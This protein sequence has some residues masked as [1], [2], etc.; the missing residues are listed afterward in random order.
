LPGSFKQKLRVAVKSVYSKEYQRLL[1]EL[2]QARKRAGMTQAALAETLEKP[3][4]FV[5]K[6]E[7]GE[8]RLD[9]IEFVQIAKA[10]D[11]NYKKII[12]LAFQ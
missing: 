11:V 3:Q 6:V 9:V 8:R 1:E 10:L 5:S 2:V 4:S 7:N 12:D